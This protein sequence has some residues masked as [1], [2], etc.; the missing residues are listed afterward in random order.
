MWKD[1]FE[2][3][4]YY[5]VNE[6]G[7]V[8]SKRTGKLII[9]DINNCGY[10][11]V[12]LQVNNKPRRYFRHRLVATHFIDNPFNLKEVNHIDSNKLNNHISNLEW[13]SREENERH[14]RINITP[15]KYKPYKVIYKDG[16]MEMYETAPPL[17]NKLG[18]SESLIRSWINQESSTYEKYGI[19]SI[20]CV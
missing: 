10:A 20:Q 13:I 4:N 8:R 14:K 5:E 3:E 6:K 15:S 18:L 2:L 11:R 7:D 17:S 9:G 1:I 19:Q 16:V 12:G